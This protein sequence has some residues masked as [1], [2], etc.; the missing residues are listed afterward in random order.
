MA[1]TCLLTDRRVAGTLGRY[2]MRNSMALVVLIRGINVGG[3]KTFRPTSLAEKLKH[4][5][6]V[7]IGA[8]GTFVIRKPVPQSA[9]RVTIARNLPFPAE[10]VICPGRDVLRMVS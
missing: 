6:V 2:S 7:N 5:D 4:L 10:I 8:A 9:L 3:H 1:R